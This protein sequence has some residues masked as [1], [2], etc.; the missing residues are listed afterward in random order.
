MLKA[1]PSEKK[2]IQRFNKNT[3]PG[4]SGWALAGC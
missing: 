2:G 3:K 1:L 4:Y